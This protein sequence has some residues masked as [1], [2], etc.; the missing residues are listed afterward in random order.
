MA[1]SPFF[2]FMQIASKVE[3]LIQAISEDQKGQQ[4]RSGR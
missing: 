2:L 1:A 4:K 3:P